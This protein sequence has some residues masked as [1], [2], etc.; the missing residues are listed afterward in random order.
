[1]L[2]WSLGYSG[3]NSLDL[4]RSSATRCPSRCSSSA[5][6]ELRT[7]SEVEKMVTEAGL[8][9]GCTGWMHIQIGTVQKRADLVDLKTFCK[10]S[11]FLECYSQESASIQ[12]RTNLQKCVARALQLTLT[13][14][15]L[16]FFQHSMRCFNTPGVLCS[17]FLDTSTNQKPRANMR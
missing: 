10:M 7:L 14:P 8:P 2:F 9:A 1:M 15:W 13:V 11:I 4:G 17:K 5:G 16:P 3:N 6:R 12:P